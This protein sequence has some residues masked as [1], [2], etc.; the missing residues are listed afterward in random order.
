FLGYNM[1]ESP[2][3]VTGTTRYLFP[4]DGGQIQAEKI[5]FVKG[6][7][8]VKVKVVKDNHSFFIHIIDP[9]EIQEDIQNDQGSNDFVEE[10]QAEL[11]KLV[12]GGKAVSKF[13]SFSATLE[14][15][16]HLSFSCYGPEGK[17]PDKKDPNLAGALSIPSVNLPTSTFTASA[18]PP[19]AAP[20]PGKNKPGKE[21]S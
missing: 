20:A 9:K 6:A 5:T 2:I 1:G 18:V 21:K 11:G 3:Q 8:M 10:Q 14:N 4:T 16:I 13:G 15:D 12:N 19:A 17:T 7:T